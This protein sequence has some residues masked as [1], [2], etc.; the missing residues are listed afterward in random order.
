MFAKSISNNFK[1]KEIYQISEH[2]MIMD[3]VFEGG[4]TLSVK[5][6]FLTDFYNL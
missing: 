4:N 5:G 1:K 6:N 2:F 3:L